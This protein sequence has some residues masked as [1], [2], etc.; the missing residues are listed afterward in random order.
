MKKYKRLFIYSLIVVLGMIFLFYGEGQAQNVAD[1]DIQPSGITVTPLPVPNYWYIKLRIMAP[2]GNLILNRSSQNESIFWALPADAE[3]GLYRYEVVVLTYDPALDSGKE[4]GPTGEGIIRQWGSFRVKGG[5]IMVPQK[6]TEDM[7]QSLWQGVIRFMAKTWDFI[8]PSAE[9]ADLYIDDASPTLYY[10]DSDDEDFTPGYDWKV[11]AEGGASDTDTN[12][13]YRIS[14]YGESSGITEIPIMELR[15]DGTN[16]A[17]SSENSIIVDYNGDITF[18]NGAVFIDRSTGIMGIGTT[19]PTWANLDIS[20]TWPQ[21]RF[22]DET[23]STYFQFEYNSPWFALEGNTEQD[24]IKIDATAPEGSLIVSSEGKVGIN[25]SPTRF[26]D[27][28]GNI[29]TTAKFYSQGVVPGFWLDE[30]D[31]GKGAYFVLDGGILQMQR[32][33]GGFGAFEASPF[34]VYISAP[35]NAFF[36]RGN[37]YLG[38]GVDPSYPI[39]SSTGAYLSAAGTWVNA[40]SREYKENIKEL[41]AEEAVNALK[42]LNPVTY[43]AK[44]DP[45]KD[46]YVGFIAEEVPEIV[47]TKDRKGLSAMEIVAVLTKVVQEQQKTVEEQQ[48]IISELS[49][50]IQELERELRLRGAVASINIK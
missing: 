8:F 42:G 29:Y 4:D 9:A 48:K 30:T 43:T 50:R 34:K 1:V 47:A 12:N 46:T 41:T 16:G 17:N 15:N 37:G 20:H 31:A 26:L 45:E 10:D 44:A 14:A 36:L 39:H 24:I 6:P 28:D 32:R 13:Y 19:T 35:T 33:A 21:I 27:V 23:D 7:K 49:E 22:T 25:K 40:S 2:D 18:A 3:D 38:L 11:R 5:M